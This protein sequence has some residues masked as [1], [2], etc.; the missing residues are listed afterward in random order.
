MTEDISYL[1][2]SMTAGFPVVKN[3]WVAK[4]TVQGLYKLQ[5]WKRWIAI[6]LGKPTVEWRDV[7]TEIEDQ[8]GK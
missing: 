1:R 6:L 2:A 8:E 5:G 4:V 3:A 7:T